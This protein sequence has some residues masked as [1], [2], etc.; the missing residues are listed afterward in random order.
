MELF[1]E[2]IWPGLELVVCMAAFGCGCYLLMGGEK[3][4]S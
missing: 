1:W 2:R 4:E 3:R